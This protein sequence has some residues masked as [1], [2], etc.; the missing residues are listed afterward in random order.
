MA[1]EYMR[2]Q[3]EDAEIKWPNFSGAPTKFKDEGRRSF[4]VVLDKATADAMAADGWNVKCKMPTDEDG[5]EF[6]FVEVVVGYK[7]KPPKI[8]AIT[9]SGRTNLTEET[10]GVL[11]SADIKTVDL[12]AQASFGKSMVSPDTRHI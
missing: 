1:K 12:I 4:N 3:I 11:D 6:C 10:V 8:I 2:F 5:E 9:S 7:I